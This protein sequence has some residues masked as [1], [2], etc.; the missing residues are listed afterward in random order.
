MLPSITRSLFQAL[1]CRW[2]DAGDED[3]VEVLI[4]DHA[5]DC[6]KPSYEFMQVYASVMIVLLPVGL[7]L[8]A[9]VGLWRLRCPAEHHALVR[10]PAE[11]HAL[12]GQQDQ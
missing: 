11:H 1:S 7:Q 9:L 3:A 10:C 4:V 2:Y 6:G 5:V 12:V 8:G